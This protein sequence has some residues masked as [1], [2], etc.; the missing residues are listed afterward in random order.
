S[1][2]SM[3]SRRNSPTSSRSS[4]NSAGNSPRR[5][6]TPRPPPSPRPPTSSSRPSRHRPR[7]RTDA[8]SG[9]S[10]DTPSTTR[11]PS[12]PRP[13]TAGRK[14]RRDVVRVTISRG[15]LARIIAKVSRALER[16]YEELLD[17]LPDEARLNV[18]ETGHK[19]NGQRQWT[20]CFRASLYT[21]FKIDPSR[22]GD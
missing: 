5:A 1:R 10:P 15:E 17:A 11:S 18:D 12:R 14:F 3:P 13:P 22:S 19:Q 4:P 9:D 7:A 21:L 16:P 8:R 20:W 2:E 6:R